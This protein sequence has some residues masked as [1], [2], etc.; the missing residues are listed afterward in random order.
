LTRPTPP[1]LVLPYPP[2]V[3]RLYR[4]RAVGKRVF[5]YKT[6]EHRDYLKAVR[7]AAGDVEPRAKPALLVVHV[8][9]FRPMRRGDIDGP[10]KA[11]FDALNGIAWEDD[12]QVV[13]LHLR[14]GDDKERPR[15][16][17][18]I[19]EVEQEA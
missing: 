7:E 16:E 4:S 2:S 10:V 14:R 3:N 5:P 15:V 13:E 17:V 6:H 19:H 12:S 11:L 9:L 18:S 1:R 8:Q